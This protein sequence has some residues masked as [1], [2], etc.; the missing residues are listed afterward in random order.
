MK[1]KKELASQRMQQPEI[2]TK[3]HILHSE[4]YK[5]QIKCR[6]NP[7]ILQLM[8]NLGIQHRFDCFPVAFG[9]TLFLFILSEF[10][11]GR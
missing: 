3:W 9:K 4:L 6:K 2:I 8:E 5:I 11:A 1:M 7:N 10:H